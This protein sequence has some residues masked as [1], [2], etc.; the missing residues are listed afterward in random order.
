MPLVHLCGH[1]FDI[2]QFQSPPLPQQPALVGAAS[3]AQLAISLCL[4][5]VFILS[6]TTFWSVF[7]GIRKQFPTHPQFCL[8][9]GSQSSLQKSAL[10]HG[11]QLFRKK[12]GSFVSDNTSL[13]LLQHHASSCM[14]FK[15]IQQWVYFQPAPG[16]SDSCFSCCSLYWFFPHYNLFF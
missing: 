1:H 3:P 2:L 12:K 8:S 9:E 10:S 13:G 15:C 11:F 5:N 16:E 7:P 6:V 4:A 14:I